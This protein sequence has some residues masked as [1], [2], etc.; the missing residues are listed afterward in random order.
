MKQQAFWKE[1]HLKLL[2]EKRTATVVCLA[3]SDNDNLF[4]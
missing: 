4:I 2:S 1:V 3:S